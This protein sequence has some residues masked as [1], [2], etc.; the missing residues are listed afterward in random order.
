MNE[1]IKH[2]YD[3]TLDPNSDRKGFFASSSL[4]TATGFF[5]LADLYNTLIH[6][7]LPELNNQANLNIWS[8]GCSDGREPYSIALAVQKW[9][10]QHPE[11]R[12]SLFELRASDITE[13]MI[14][15]GKKNDYEI[16]ESETR[17]LSEYS[18]HVTF[19]GASRVSI[20]SEVCRKINFVLEDIFSH[21]A[22]Q[23]YHILVCTNVLFY[24]EM[25]F[26]KKIVMD[27][28]QNLRSDGFIYLESMGSRFM[29]SLDME[30]IIPGSHFFRF[31]DA[32]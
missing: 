1:N 26:R 23:K 20:N 21:K 6:N 18:E 12:T 19:S 7:V 8:A 2:V 10:K 3:A 31:N 5:R 17:R 16:G 30:R 9:I 29:R 27:L 28:V 15:T 4:V 32:G 25:E 22:P 24:Y 13:T 14:N 11:S